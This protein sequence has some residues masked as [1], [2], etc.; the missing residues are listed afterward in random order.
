VAYCCLAL[1]LG[2]PT[3]AAAHAA[4]YAVL[5]DVFFF[6]LSKEA[7]ACCCVVQV[8]RQQL[9]QVDLLDK[10]PMGTADLQVPAGGLTVPH[11]RTGRLALL[12]GMCSSG[13]QDTTAGLACSMRSR[14]C[15]AAILRR[16][17]DAQS[18][19]TSYAEHCPEDSEW[20]MNS[21]LLGN[22]L[23]QAFLSFQN[24]CVCVSNNKQQ[25]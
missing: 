14:A 20:A 9:I 15:A 13:S 16:S 6:A 19:C 10:L 3:L 4:V 25:C 1:C 23:L 12:A 17:I 7:R 18:I 5:G 2:L 21:C 11:I 22:L 24:T 8:P